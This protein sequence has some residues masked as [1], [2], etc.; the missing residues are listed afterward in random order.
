MHLLL[1]AL[2]AATLSPCAHAPDSVRWAAQ[3]R[4]V[5]ITRDDWGIAH[6]HGSTDA[7]AVFGMIYTQAEDDFARIELNYLDALGRRAEAEGEN[8]V[9]RDLRMRLFI[10]PDTLRARY[11]AS[12]GW[13]RRLTDAWADGLNYYLRTHP[14]VK[15]KV[16]TRFEPWMALS[17]T[18]G[19]IGGDIESISLRELG[20][21]YGDSVDRPRPTPS[22]AGPS[23]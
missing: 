21:F 16:L 9:I 4:R 13:L 1:L 5:T 3:A 15:P 7:D 2:A 8:A 19:S 23:S 14:E 11:A 6:V 18:E 17:F 10:D 20:A 12:P 22:T